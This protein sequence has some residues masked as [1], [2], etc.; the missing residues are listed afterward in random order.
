MQT[1][2]GSLVYNNQKPTRKRIDSRLEPVSLGR[3]RAVASF[4]AQSCSLD[5]SEHWISLG[6]VDNQTAL[7]SQE[8]WI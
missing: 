8:L 6:L 1:L 4:N 7:T 2:A 3:Q 5:P